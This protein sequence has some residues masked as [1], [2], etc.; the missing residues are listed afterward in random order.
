MK[1]FE[2]YLFQLEL[3]KTFFV[4]LKLFVTMLHPP[5]CAWGANNYLS[6]KQKI[7]FLA[8]KRWRTNITE[9]AAQ[10]L[11]EEI[12]QEVTN[13]TGTTNKK[14]RVRSRLYRVKIK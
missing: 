13:I 10:I 7:V 3:R 2:K 11:N 14:T 4:L 6:D 1:D 8:Q 12:A 9:E 5:F